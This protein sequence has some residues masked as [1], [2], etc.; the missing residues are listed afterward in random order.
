LFLILFAIVWA[1]GSV[2]EG[3]LLSASMNVII[4]AMPDI[5]IATI[6]KTLSATPLSLKLNRITV[7]FNP[8]FL[9]LYYG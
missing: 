5:V 2:L 4:F 8:W 1:V 7:Q 6:C 9:E 3:E